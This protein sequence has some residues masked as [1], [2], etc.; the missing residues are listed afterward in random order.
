MTKMRHPPSHVCSCTAL[1]ATESRKPAAFFFLLSRRSF[2]GPTLFLPIMPL[3]LKKK[4]AEGG[5]VKPAIDVAGPAYSPNSR[6]K[7]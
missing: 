5:D 3:P 6:L 2:A 7:E 1:S 4:K